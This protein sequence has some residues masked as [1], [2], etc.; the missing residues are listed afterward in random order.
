MKSV[1]IEDDLHADL[2]IL[3]GVLQKKNL[4][5]TIRQALNSAGYSEL[6]FEKMLELQEKVVE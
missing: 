4:T 3:K 6:F 5:E 1:K 2:M